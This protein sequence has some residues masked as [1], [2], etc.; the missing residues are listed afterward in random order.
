MIRYHCVEQTD[1]FQE[2][3]LGYHH[4]TR[5]KWDEIKR[6]TPPKGCTRTEE[7]LYILNPDDHEWRSNFF[8]CLPDY[9]AAYFGERYAQLFKTKDRKLANLWLRQTMGEKVTPRIKLVK[10]RYATN[11]HEFKKDLDNLP[12]FERE[13][14]KEFAWRVSMFL[15]STFDDYVERYTTQAD[16]DDEI[17]QRTDETYTQLALIIDSLG[18][19]APY[20]AEHTKGRTKIE[21]NKLESGILRML[22]AQWIEIQLKRIRDIQREHLAIAVGQVQKKASIYVSKSTKNEWIEQKKRNKEFFKAHELENEDGERVSLADMVYASVANP[23]IRRCELMV[24]MRGFEDIADETGCVGGFFTITAPSKYHSVH[25]QGGFVKNWSGANPRDTQKYLCT[26]WAKI[27]SSLKRQ[28]INIFGFR[29]VE[30]HHDGTP[31]WHLLMFYRQEN[32]DAIIETMRDYATAEDAD[33][34]NSENA[35]KARFHFEKIDKEKGTATG[36]IAKYISKNI[37][38][39]ALDDEKDH[40]TGEPLK[41]LAKATTAWAS[42]WRIR[43]FQQIGGAPVTV[44][45]EC[46]RLAGLKLSNSAMDAV[47]ASADVGCWASYVNAQGGPL[48]SRDDL[49]VRLAY[50][51]TPQGNQYAEE[52]RKIRGIFEQLQ[53]EES[54]VI[55]RITKWKI[56]KKQQNEKEEAKTTNEHQRVSDDAQGLVLNQ[57]GAAVPWSSVNNCTQSKK[58]SEQFFSYKG[59]ILD[60]RQAIKLFLTHRGELASERNIDIL[61]KGSLLSTGFNTSYVWRSGQLHE[62][63]EVEMW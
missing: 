34:L 49:V 33:E 43:Q 8:G 28:D 61:Q 42:R 40:D 55:T 15:I 56:V 48:V 5:A 12:T 50:E 11:N 20:K 53:G 13:Q 62:Y 59:Q 52:V 3:P 32:E 44:Y 41:E 38:G 21:L 17:Y 29:V 25:H 51:I 7:K 47:V 14:I 36:Y 60:E 18:I 54:T 31:H 26:I 35:K 23:A 9:L 27:R 45:R 10:K 6:T 58:Q 63:H 16:S 57:D 39:Y 46:R 24:R 2:F 22:D 19:N 4:V 37:D 1:F 30:P